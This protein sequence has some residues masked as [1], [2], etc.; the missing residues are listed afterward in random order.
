[1]KNITKPIFIDKIEIIK[2]DLKG[3]VVEDICFIGYK[4]F[5]CLQLEYRFNLAMSDKFYELLESKYGTY[6]TEWHGW[7]GSP[8][9]PENQEK[10]VEVLEEFKELYIELYFKG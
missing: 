9:L 8:R 2:K 3:E 4:K 10:R 6:S 1:M 5:I 7:F